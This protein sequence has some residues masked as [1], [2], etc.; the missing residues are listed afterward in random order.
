MVNNLVNVQLVPRR[1]HN[2]R[3]G[4]AKKAIQTFKNHFKADLSSLHPDCP[5]TEW[6]RFLPQAFLTLNQLC[7]STANPKISIYAYL[8]GPFDFNKIHLAPPGSKVIIH[9][10]PSQRTLWD[11]NGK[12]G[13]LCGSGSNSLPLY[14]LF[15]PSHQTR[16]R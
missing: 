13:F 6:D 12:I 4:L 11:V 3:A 5:I 16:N 15:L 9:S 8:Y 2:H 1:P 7:P 10:K 14:E